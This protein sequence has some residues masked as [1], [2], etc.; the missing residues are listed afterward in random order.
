M[1]LDLGLSQRLPPHRPTFD[2]AEV[3]RMYRTIPLFDKELIFMPINI[4]NTHWTLV[5]MDMAAKTISYFF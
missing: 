2:Y 5:A 4:T 1:Y 3:S